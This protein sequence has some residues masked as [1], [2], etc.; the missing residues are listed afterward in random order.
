MDIASI[1]LILGIMLLATI[2]ISIPLLGQPKETRPVTAISGAEPLGGAVPVDT[3]RASLLVERDHLLKSLQDLETDYALGKIPAEDYPQQRSDLL[4]AGA[5]V[6][7]QLDELKTIPVDVTLQ[8]S[9]QKVTSN[10]DSDLELLINERR[11]QRQEKTS[12]FCHRCG[13]PVLQ[14]DL[15]CSHCGAVVKGEEK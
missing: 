7:Q 9:T 6:L 3:R 1:L 2:Y 14:S 11:R 10:S 4:K 12:G 13:K 8:S 15:F 5:D